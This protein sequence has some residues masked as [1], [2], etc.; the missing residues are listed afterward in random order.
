MHG[1]LPEQEVSTIRLTD[2]ERQPC[3]I[4]TRVMGYHRPIN[5]FNPGKKSEAAERVS[6]KEPQMSDLS[7]A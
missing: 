2:E 7:A 1:Q 5:A 3:E 4:W 6:F